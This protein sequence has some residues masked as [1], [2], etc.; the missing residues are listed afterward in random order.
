[1]S[2]FQQDLAAVKP[3]GRARVMRALAACMPTP[4]L[5]AALQRV[6]AAPQELSS[7]V[8]THIYGSG[9]GDGPSW[10]FLV[11]GL[12]AESLSMVERSASLGGQ[13]T[14]NA[15]A[16]AAACMDRMVKLWHAAAA[17]ECVIVRCPPPYP[18]PAVAVSRFCLFSC[19]GP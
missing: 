16:A 7:S 6:P 9:H 18:G 5:C 2:S 3:V 1:M 12:L 15:V 17:T 11:D 8:S 19:F 14:Y 13:V 10:S 4:A